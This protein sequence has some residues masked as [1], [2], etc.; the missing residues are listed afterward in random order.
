LLRLAVGIF[1]MVGMSNAM[2]AEEPE[3]KLGTVDEIQPAEAIRE[4]ITGPDA[5]IFSETLMTQWEAASVEAV[6]SVL[7]MSG[8]DVMGGNVAFLVSGNCVLGYKF[9]T[10]LELIHAREIVG[11]YHT[12]HVLP[13]K[14]HLDEALLA[15]LAAAGNPVAEFHVGLVAAWARGGKGDRAASLNWL[16]RSAKQGYTPAVLALGMAL[17]GPDVIHDGVEFIGEPPPTDEFTDLVR[18]CYWLAIAAVYS[19]RPIVAQAADWYGEMLLAR[20][21][22]E[23]M[24]ACQQLLRED[25]DP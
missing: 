9:V 16:Q 1:L 25:S 13:A 21:S 2:A 24:A 17:S 14:K 8:P 7:L 19:P 20:M 11:L 22:D 15:E 23:E 5:W 12:E 6:D 4:R 10:I 3:C 18:A